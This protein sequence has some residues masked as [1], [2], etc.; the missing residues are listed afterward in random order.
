MQDERSVV[1]ASAFK[2]FMYL[3]WISENKLK[4]EYYNPSLGAK[5]FKEFYKN[6]LHMIAN[7]MTIDR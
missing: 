3:P 4:I 5:K 6:K 1:R 2:T 7:F